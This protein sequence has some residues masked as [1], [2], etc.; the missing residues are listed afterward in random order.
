MQGVKSLLIDFSL[1]LHRVGVMYLCHSHAVIT[2]D[3]RHK[4]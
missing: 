3:S 4:I 2:I 1:G